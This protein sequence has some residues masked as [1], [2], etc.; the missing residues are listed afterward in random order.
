MFIKIVDDFRKVVKYLENDI[1]IAG[2]NGLGDP[3]IDY[4][5]I[6]FNGDAECGHIQNSEVCIPWP[7]KDAGGIATPSEDAV[8]GQW[9][10]G[11]TLEKRMCNGDCSY[12]TMVMQRIKTI[13]NYESADKD[14]ND[15]F[16]ECC[17]TAFRPY[18]IYVIALLIIAKYHL[19]DDVIVSTDGENNNWYDG[20]IICHNLLGYGKLF[21]ID[22]HGRLINIEKGVKDEQGQ[23]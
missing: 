10:A 4:D 7:D 1:G 12:E 22:E 16:F 14:R 9:F 5:R 8:S 19:K 23:E 11:Y 15:L 6:I 20:K 3:I 18:D 21:K 17:K 13:I 2:G